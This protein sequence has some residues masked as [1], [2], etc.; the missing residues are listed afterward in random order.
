MISINLYSFCSERNSTCGFHISQKNGKPLIDLFEIKENSG[1]LLGNNLPFA[2]KNF[3]AEVLPGQKLDDVFWR[4]TCGIHQSEL[5]FHEHAEWIYQIDLSHS[6]LGGKYFKR[7]LS[8]YEEALNSNEGFAACLTGGPPLPQYGPSKLFVIPV[9]E[10]PN[11]I[12][13]FKPNYSDENSY[14]PIMVDTEKFMSAW[15]QE[16]QNEGNFFPTYAHESSLEKSIEYLPEGPDIDYPMEIA[17]LSY[18]GPGSKFNFINGMHRTI[19]LAK[20][21]APFIPIEIDFWSP[22][23]EKDF[24]RQFSWFSTPTAMLPQ[25]LTSYPQ[26]EI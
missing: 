4:Y 26:P 11:K 22:E 13:Y 19:N 18:G 12:L 1:D 8:F 7:P 6:D 10:H 15:I 23:D 20:T 9:R 24:I 3:L 17:C 21:G 16:Y 5:K 25:L 14:R 2:C